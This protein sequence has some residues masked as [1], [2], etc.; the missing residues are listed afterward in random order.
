MGR[1]LFGGRAVISRLMATVAVVDLVAIA[2]FVGLG[3]LRHA[4]TLAAGIETYGQFLLGWLIAAFLFRAYTPRSV[5]SPKRAL[6]IGAVTWAVAA[7]FG[8]VIRIII[9]PL[10]SFAPSFVVVSIAAG[11]VL[12]AGGRGLL[13]ARVH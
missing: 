11:A 1:V 4:G 5:S 3:E 12:V 9:D 10:A 2:V 6:A 13:A 7:V 8:Q